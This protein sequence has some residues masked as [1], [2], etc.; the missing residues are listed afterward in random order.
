MNVA[1]ANAPANAPA[2]PR[3][4]LAEGGRRMFV[5]HRG[6]EGQVWQ[7]GQTGRWYSMPSPTGMTPT[8]HGPAAQLRRCIQR[9]E[10]IADRDAILVA[11]DR[12]ESKGGIA[13]LENIG[14]GLGAHFQSLRA[15]ALAGHVDVTDRLAAVMKIARKRRVPEPFHLVTDGVVTTVRPGVS[16]STSINGLENAYFVGSDACYDS[17]NKFYFGVI[18][19]IGKKTVTIDPGYGESHRRLTIERFAWRNHGPIEAKLRNNRDWCD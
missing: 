7:D 5:S 2:K 10:E 15:R 17:Y 12:F 11:A 4:R 9:I 8:S 6:A 1:A 14:A 3:V 19:S 18:V 16:I 13:K